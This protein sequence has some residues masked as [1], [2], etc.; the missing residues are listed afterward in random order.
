MYRTVPEIFGKRK[1]IDPLLVFRS[2]LDVDAKQN[3]KYGFICGT[4]HTV[5]TVNFNSLCINLI[6]GFSICNNNRHQGTVL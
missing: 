5:C 2:P 1:L 6:N 4:L 3:K